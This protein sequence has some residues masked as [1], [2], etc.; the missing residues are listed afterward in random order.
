MGGQPKTY[1]SNVRPWWFFSK[2]SSKPALGMNLFDSGDRQGCTLTNVPRHGKSLYKPYI[3]LQ[4]VGVYGLLSPRIPIFSPYKYHGSTRTL[5]VHPSL[6]LDRRR[7][8]NLIFNSTVFQT[9]KLYGECH[10]CQTI[11]QCLIK[12]VL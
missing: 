11:F 6:S 2:K 5:G 9:V 3:S 7:L 1:T 4:H 12:V 10:L 8:H